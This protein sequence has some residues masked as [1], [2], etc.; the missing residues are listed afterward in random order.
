MALVLRT[1]VEDCIDRLVEAFLGMPY[2][3]Y[4]E[5]DLHCYIYHLMLMDEELSKP[6]EVKT[7]EGFDVKSILI[8]KEYPTK[9]LYRRH[10]DRDSEIVRKRKKGERVSRGHFD[11]CVWNP[12]HLEDR[13]F[14]ASGWKSEEETLIAIELSLNEHWKR[15]EYHVQWDLLKLNDPMNSVSYGYILFFVREY[16]YDRSGLPHDYFIQRLG[17]FGNES[18]TNIIY[19]ENEHGKKI[20]GV[21]S[22]TRFRDYKRLL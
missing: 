14:R 7:R 4:T 5:G 21:M 19:V 8:H 15:A 11:L 20:K 17:R 1:A 3:F 18:K 6:V 2:M 22:N 16:P 12:L 9:G 13:F 10:N